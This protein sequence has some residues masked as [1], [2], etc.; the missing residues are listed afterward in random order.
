MLSKKADTKPRPSAVHSDGAGSSSTGII[1]A[2]ATRHTRKTMPCAACGSA[3][4]LALLSS[5]PS[6]IAIQT[7]SA[8]KLNAM[9]VEIVP[10]M[11]IPTMTSLVLSTGGD[12][13][14]GL[15]SGCSEF[16]CALAK[17]PKNEIATIAP[18]AASTTHSGEA[19]AIQIIVVVVSPMTEPA[20]P[21][22]DAAT[23]AAR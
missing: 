15:I 2:A 20:P 5:W 22:L 11:I 13:S 18:I 12:A 14:S 17:I 9:L 4:Q 16:C 3:F 6:A 23:I 1:D 10:T 21:A 19:P 7:P 8:G